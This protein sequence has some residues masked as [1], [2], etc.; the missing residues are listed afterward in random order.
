MTGQPLPSLSSDAIDWIGEMTGERI[1]RSGIRPA[2]GAT[3]STLF[4][5]PTEMSGGDPRFVLRL[6]TNSA[7]LQNEPDLAP[8]EFAALSAARAAGLPVPEPVAFDPDGQRCGLPA[9]LMTFLAGSVVVQPPDF[10]IWLDEMAAKA[11]EIHSHQQ[12][13]ITWHYAS[14]VND[15]GLAPPEWSEQPRRWEKAIEI[16]RAGPP[17]EETT[18]IHRDYHPTN[19]LWR[20]RITGIVDWINACRGP[21]AVDVAHCRANLKSMFGVAAAEQFLAAYQRYASP[22]FVYH[23]YWDIESLVDQLPDPGFYPPWLD[24]GLDPIAVEIRR[25]RHEEWLDL[26]LSRYE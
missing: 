5:V 20:Q 10:D 23:P 26:V 14:W 3:S 1:D 25:A 24:F 11:R 8:H 4:L 12:V 22:D 18:F 17:D 7:W 15:K 21:A 6:H 13:V 2:T 9:L 16:F 19:I